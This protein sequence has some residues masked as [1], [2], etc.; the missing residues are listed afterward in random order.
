TASARASRSRLRNAS[1]PRPSSSKNAEAAGNLTAR[2]RAGTCGAWWSWQRRVQPFGPP[3]RADR[4]NPTRRAQKT[5]PPHRSFFRHALPEGFRGSG[6][7]LALRPVGPGQSVS[8][9]QFGGLFRFITRGGVTRERRTAV[10]AGSTGIG[11]DMRKHTSK[12]RLSK[13]TLLKL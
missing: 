12:L 9:S 2:W 10:E 7:K 1:C 6:W 13:E 4:F 8:T 3:H 5:R 11:N